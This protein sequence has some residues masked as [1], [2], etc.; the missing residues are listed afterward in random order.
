MVKSI[1]YTSR[2]LDHAFNGEVCDINVKSGK[3][4]MAS[5]FLLT[6]PLVVVPLVASSRMILG[7][8]RKR[9]RGKDVQLSLTVVACD[10]LTVTVRRRSLKMSAFCIR[11][12][13]LH[14]IDD[15]C[16]RGKIIWCQGDGLI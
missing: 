14:E 4:L 3:D 11:N 10:G 6:C 1:S 2:I 9:K 5:P 13:A 8:E 15:K 7:R 12:P 16:L